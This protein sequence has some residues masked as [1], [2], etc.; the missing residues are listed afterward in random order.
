[1]AKMAVAAFSAGLLSVVVSVLGWFG[2]IAGHSVLFAD[3]IV[4]GTLGLPA[5]VVPDADAGLGPSAR[6]LWA[7]IRDH[8]LGALD[9][10][11]AL[12]HTGVEAEPT[13][14]LMVIFAFWVY[15]SD[16]WW[17]DPDVPEPPH[18][19]PDDAANRRLRAGLA[20]VPRG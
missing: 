19:A 6:A 14:A 2:F 3:K 13:V 7:A 8:T 10:S 5:H 16:W 15:H 9:E 17:K 20:G 4:A 11:V 1:M 12:I 18:H